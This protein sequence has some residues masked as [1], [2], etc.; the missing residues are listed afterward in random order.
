[1]NGVIPQK[2]QATKLT[3]GETG[4]LYDFTTIKVVSNKLTL[5]FKNTSLGIAFGLEYFH[6]TTRLCYMCHQT[7]AYVLFLLSFGPLQEVVAHWIAESRIAIEEIRLLTLKAAHCID[8]VGSA[9]AKK[10]VRALG[11]PPAKPSL[12]IWHFRSHGTLIAL[13]ILEA[14]FR[15]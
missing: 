10:E 15:L 14:W 3:K 5:P 11:S 6:Q 13:R 7:P 9:G 2:P 4:N 1:M 8:T 12:P